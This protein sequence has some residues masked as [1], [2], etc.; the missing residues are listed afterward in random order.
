MGSSASV[1]AFDYD[2]QLLADRANY[3]IEVK[4]DEKHD[5]ATA[6][7]RHPDAAE[8]LISSA[9]GHEHIYG[10]FAA[11]AK[12]HPES[13]C[14]GTRVYI[15]DDA[16]ESDK[17]KVKGRGAFKWLTYKQVDERIQAVGKGIQELGIPAKSNCG[18]FSI[19]RAE[20]CIAALGNYSCGYR[21]VALYDTLGDSAVEYIINHA[22]LPLIFVAKDTLPKVLSGLEKF[23]N[24]KYIVQFDASEDFENPHE[25]VD[26]KD[27]A[28][29]KEKNVELLGFSE[30]IKKGSG[31][32]KELTTPKGDDLALIMYTSGT[33]GMP[34]GV[35]LA[36]SCIIAQGGG[37]PGVVAEPGDA[38]LSFLPLAH[39]FE[40]VVQSYLWSTGSK[41]AFYQGDPKKLVN[42]FSD[43]EP[44][45]ICGVPRVFQRMYQRVFEGLND[46]SCLIR[47]M[48]GSA[49]A[50]QAAAVRE[51]R[52]IES[53]DARVFNA[54][55]QRIGMAKAK[56]IITGGAPCPPYLIEF[57]RVVVGAVVIQGYGLTETSAGA[58]CV[59]VEDLTIGHCG[60]PARWAEIRLKNVEEMNYLVTD[61]PPK[62]EVQIRGAGVFKG[63]YKNEE[64]TRDTFDGDWFCSGDIG[65]FNPN[66]TLSIID[67]KKNIF[68]LAHGEYIAV[69]KVEAV[70][71]KC[72][73]V[74]QLWVYGNS[75]KPQLVGVA[76]PSAEVIFRLANEK[77][78]WKSESKPGKPEFIGDFRKVWADNAAVFE[79]LILDEFKKLEG[80]LKGFEKVAKWHFETNVDGIFQAFTVENDCL[81]PTFK[82]RRNNLLQ[83]YIEEVKKMYTDLGDPPKADERWLGK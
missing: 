13:P 58:T 2:A 71:A 48:F 19:N 29:C 11:G 39:I 72:T 81:T 53:W 14:F 5:N 31:S 66:G 23:A 7:R 78:L 20:W 47:Y 57:L 50:A 83:K 51:G 12:H 28:F 22:E 30:L 63:Y 6:P 79:G 9:L 21:T 49:Y 34:K 80:E 18:I 70:Y 77:G 27:V 35:M 46:K 54:L 82:L 69:E 17:L 33:T 61:N 36:H 76:V 60:A 64:A 10:Q 26:P 41:I 1:E 56:Y 43:V 38:Y 42:D 73:I 25:T 62:G 55:K 67:R 68:K 37:V 65:R 74:S 8:K 59:P 16:K 4:S 40:T 3:S 44:A 15:Y 32:T 24:L 45:L 75:Y 52:R